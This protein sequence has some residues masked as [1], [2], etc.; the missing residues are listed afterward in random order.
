MMKQEVRARWDERAINAFGKIEE[1][2][3]ELERQQYE[4]EIGRRLLDQAQDE[5]AR[6]TW[7]T[8][9]DVLEMIVGLTEGHI[10]E[11]QE[12]MDLCDAIGC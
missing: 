8:Q 10:K 4:L 1:L 2:Q 11:Q 12:E 6:Q 7:Q 3:Y 5:S 9:V